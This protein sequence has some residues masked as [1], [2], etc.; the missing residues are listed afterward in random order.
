MTSVMPLRS[1]VCAAAPSLCLC[2]FAFKL[3]VTTP[4]NG[5]THDVSHAFAFFRMRG[6]AIF[7]SL[8]LCVENPLNHIL[9]KLI[10]NLTP[11]FRGTFKKSPP[12][13]QI[14][15]SRD[16]QNRVVFFGGKPLFS[17]VVVT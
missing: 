7:V 16:G 2:V 8:R 6:G 12:R 17:Q 1:S 4:S 9:V 15:K 3:Y 11:F 14:F 10:L 13:S 5:V